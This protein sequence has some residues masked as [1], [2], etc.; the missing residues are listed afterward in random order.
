MTMRYWR[1]PFDQDKV[2]ISHGEVHILKERCKGCRF[3]TEYCPQ[4]VLK[5]SE[6]FNTAGYH[7]ACVEEG[8]DCL[9]CG[10]CQMLCPEFAIYVV[11]KDGSEAH[12]Q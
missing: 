9:D 2:K 7:P 3:C 4:K 11:P 5:E 10:L 6:E 8:T 12:G 1:K